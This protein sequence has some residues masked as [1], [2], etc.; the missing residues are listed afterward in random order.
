MGALDDLL[1]SN[2][3]SGRSEQTPSKSTKST[4]A[5]C[6]SAL[7]IGVKTPSE[8]EFEDAVRLT[9]RSTPLAQP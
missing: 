2:S 4:M 3:L 6:A 1:A 5:R 7:P 8:F 9:L